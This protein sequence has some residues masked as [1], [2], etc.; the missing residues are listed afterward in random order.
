MQLFCFVHLILWSMAAS[1]LSFK[2]K[3]RSSFMAK[4]GRELDIL[5]RKF[6]STVLW[7]LR[8]SSYEAYRAGYHYHLWDQLMLH[9][10]HT[11]IYSFLHEKMWFW[12]TGF[13]VM[14]IV[15]AI[16]FNALP[17]TDL[18]T[19]QLP[20]LFYNKFL[21]C[22]TK[23]WWECVALSQVPKMFFCHNFPDL[24]RIGSL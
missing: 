13:L 1:S 11:S 23:E 16:E 6:C 15:Y 12:T 3:E 20:S 9:F 17:S 22:E 2:G 24:R 4:E 8:I 21:L 5:P 7:L 19:C 18:Q 10:A 14:Q